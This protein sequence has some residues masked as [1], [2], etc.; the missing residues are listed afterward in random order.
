MEDLLH[1]YE[2]V[3]K[4]YEKYTLDDIKTM[5][6]DHLSKLCLEERIQ[7]ITALNN[8]TIYNVIDEWKRIIINNMKDDKVN[9]RAELGEYYKI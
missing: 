7:F 4:C 6:D 8:L 5:R 3:K 1:K 9:R 2:A